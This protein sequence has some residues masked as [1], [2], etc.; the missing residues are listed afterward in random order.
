MRSSSVGNGATGGATSRYC[1]FPN[2]ALHDGGETVADTAIVRRLL[3]DRPSVRALVS[4]TLPPVVIASILLIAPMHV[5]SREMTWD[6]LFNLDG[7]WRL[8]NGQIPHFDFHTELGALPF[9]TTA[10]GFYLLGPNPT[11]FLVGE[12]VFAVLVLALSI[13][14]V[15]ERLPLV[16]ATIFTILCTFISLMPL[17]YGDGFGAY[18]FAMPYNRFG[19]SISGIL[20]VLLFIGPLDVQR[21]VW[22]DCFVG[23]AVLLLL[24]YD[25]ITYFAIGM[26][27][28]ALAL[29]VPGH[30]CTK[31][32]EWL[33]VFVVA[34][35]G[36]IAPFNLDYLRDIINST[37][38]GG[39]QILFSRFVVANLVN[40]P[41][42]HAVALACGLLLTATASREQFGAEL[43]GAGSW[44]RPV[45]CCCRRMPRPMGYRA[46]L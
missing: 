16:P 41:A 31:R 40:D 14:A 8:Y 36:A 30:V 3:I 38:A 10:L 27:A 12:C 18:S 11:G 45:Y 25:K 29:I 22:K 43:Q 17:N 9:A 33:A 6:L 24:Y 1:G 32:R 34:A 39:A 7:A 28:L 26:A 15:A 19:W 21:S 20:F 4:T 2:A 35:L 44:R 23:L 42:E 37:S 46:M 13:A 5:Y